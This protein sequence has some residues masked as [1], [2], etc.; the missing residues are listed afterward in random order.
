MDS[1]QYLSTPMESQPESQSE[2]GFETQLIPGW[3]I[4]CPN[5]FVRIELLKYPSHIYSELF[6]VTSIAAQKDMLFTAHA[7]G[8]TIQ[9]QI[10]KTSTENPVITQNLSEE[11]SNSQKTRTDIS[12]ALDF[13]EVKSLLEIDLEHFPMSVSTGKHVIQHYRY[14]RYSSQKAVWKI[15]GPN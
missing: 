7:I 15:V 11:D 13:T 2:R 5:I 3:R 9:T 4:V 8:D 12:V 1:S 14:R 6:P 10:E